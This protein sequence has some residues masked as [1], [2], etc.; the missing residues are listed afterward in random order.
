VIDEGMARASDLLLGIAIG[1]YVLALLLHSLELAFAAR[2]RPAPIGGGAVD[3]LPTPLPAALRPSAPRRWPAY[4]GAVAVG[5]TV[6]AWLV[7]LASATTRGLAVDRVPWG[8]MY[9]YSSV[10]SLAAVGGWLVLLRRSPDLRRL[11]ALVLFPVVVFLAVAAVALYAPARP[12]IPALQSYWLTIHVSAAML[13]SGLFLVGFV[14]NVTFLVRLRGRAAVL[15]RGERL[16]DLAFRVTALAFLVW[17]F[18]VIAGAVWAEPAWGR[19]WGWD[20][21]ETWAFITW[22][23]YAGY[24]HARVT[25]G[26]RGRRAAWLGVLGFAALLFC[27]YGVN[28]WI[29]GLHSYAGV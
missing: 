21:K 18:A 6:V 7:H 26:W 28:L 16:D 29:S 19:Y 20:P 12:L 23:F 4:A 2:R 11:G 13:A 24:L 25:H 17:T 27:Y 22:V 3:I 14:L 15:P 1:G 8:N 9:E 10:V 5:V